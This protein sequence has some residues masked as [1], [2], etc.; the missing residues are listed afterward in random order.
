MSEKRSIKQLCE[1]CKKSYVN[2]RKHRE[3]EYHKRHAAQQAMPFAQD[4][5]EREAGK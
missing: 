1:N 2:I 3:G 5:R 4:A